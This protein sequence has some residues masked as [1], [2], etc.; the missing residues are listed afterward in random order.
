[1]LVYKYI[2]IN[3]MVLGNTNIIYSTSMQFSKADSCIKT[4]FSD[5]LGTISELVPQTSGNLHI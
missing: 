5:V 1:M 4:W 3:H 2:I